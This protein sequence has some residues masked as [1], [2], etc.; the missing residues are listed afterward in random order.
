VTKPG[1]SGSE[2]P[3]QAEQ[4]PEPETADS[5]AETRP[6]DAT[7]PE[8]PDSPSEAEDADAKDA[9]AEDT[10]GESAEAVVAKP[11]EAEAAEAK[12]AKAKR[13]D[14]KA[15]AAKASASEDD[16]P[17]MVE[18]EKAPPPP[19]EETLRAKSKAP[20]S[21]D[22]PPPR[23]L[24]FSFYFFAASGLV[25]LLNAIVALLDKQHLI[26]DQIALDQN[27]RLTPDQIASVVTQILWIFLVIA[28]VFA[29]FVAL[30]GYK[31]TEGT[32]RARTLVTI[33]SVMLVLFQ[34]F[35]FRVPTAFGD[36]TAI[37]SA[38]LALVGLTLI[39]SPTARAYFPPRQPLS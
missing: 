31:A 39:W 15:A 13:A 12:Q 34:M 5:A 23:T 33:F 1:N 17:L 36:F 19:R 6:E 21:F 18:L 11:A 9:E 2:E 4:A 24:K 8:A 3:K 28:V 25:W 26:D 29:A 22:E 32:R 35:I 14:A 30:F 7:A 16:E 20:R 27:S 38:F 37:L 10:D